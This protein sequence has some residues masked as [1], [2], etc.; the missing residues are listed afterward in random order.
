MNELRD[1]NISYTI[2]EAAKLMKMSPHWVWLRINEGKI[3]HLRKGT[4]IFISADEI[5]R[6]NKKGCE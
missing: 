4:K 3:K 6:I 1:L 5:N 2:K